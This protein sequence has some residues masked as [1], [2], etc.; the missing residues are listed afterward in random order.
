VKA[1]PEHVPLKII[2]FEA[3][4]QEFEHYAIQSQQKAQGTEVSGR[5]KIVTEQSCIS[6]FLLCRHLVQPLQWTR[7]ALSLVDF[8]LLFGLVL[9][10]PLH[11]QERK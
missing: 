3:W 10:V 7:G 4:R 5:K 9:S 6:S 8:A 2:S 11:P 1:D